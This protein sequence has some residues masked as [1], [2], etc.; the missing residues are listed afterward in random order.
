[1]HHDVSFIVIATHSV[2]RSQ[3]AVT[4]YISSKQPTTFF[5]FAAQQYI[6]NL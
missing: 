4:A 3:K 6:Q 5:C 1:M 2:V